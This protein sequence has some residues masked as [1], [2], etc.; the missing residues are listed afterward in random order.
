MGGSIEVQLRPARNRLE[1]NLHGKV[2]VALLRFLLVSRRYVFVHAAALTR[3][4]RVVLISTRPDDGNAGFR[5]RRRSGYRS[6]NRDVAIL[7]PGGPML[8]YPNPVPI[9]VRDAT[10]ETQDAP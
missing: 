10:L 4:G 8:C 7:S 6:L 3:N 5:L 9:E 2:V 1:R